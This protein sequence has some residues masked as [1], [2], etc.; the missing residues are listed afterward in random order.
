MENAGL[1]GISTWQDKTLFVLTFLAVFVLY[2]ALRPYL[3]YIPFLLKILRLIYFL[4]NH[5]RSSMIGVN[6]IMKLMSPIIN[7]FQSLPISQVSEYKQ[8]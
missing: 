4:V 6:Y 7:A 3:P 2:S 5:I 1:G 8:S